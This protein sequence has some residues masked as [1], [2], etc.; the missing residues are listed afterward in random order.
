MPKIVWNEN[1]FSKVKKRIPAIGRIMELSGG[2][3]LG[4][5][6]RSLVPASFQTI[7]PRADFIEVGKDYVHGLLGADMAS[8][9][10]LQLEN[11]PVLL[12]ANHLGVDYHPFV[13]QGNVLFGLA[14]SLSE[15]ALPE[16]KRVMPVMAFGSVSL[17]N[18]VY[19][20]GII[21]SREAASGTLSEPE[22][23]PVKFNVF[24]AGLRRTAASFAPPFS[25]A[26]I[27][28][29]MKAVRRQYMA[30]AIGDRENHVLTDLLENEYLSPDLLERDSYSDQ[31]A[32]INHR[33]WPRL[34]T[35]ETRRRMPDLVSM[36]IERIVSPLIIKDLRDPDS[37]LHRVLFD[38]GL[39]E[40][41]M[42]NLEG[43]FGCWDRKRLEY[44][45]DDDL[46][47][48]ERER[49]L[50][51]SGT[52]FFW[53]IS[54][55]GRLVRLALVFDGGDVYLD[56]RDEY[57]QTYRYPYT[58]DGL[59]RGL[60]DRS[61]LP[62]LFVTF[63]EVAFARG[64]RCFGGFFQAGYLPAMQKGLTGALKKNGYRDWA[65]KVDI[66]STADY[67]TGMTV[68]LAHYRD[69]IQPAGMVEVLS[70]EGIAE[71]DL[72]LIGQLTVDEANL[73][74]LV[75]ICRNFAVEG[76]G[77]AR[78]MVLVDQDQMKRVIRQMVKIKL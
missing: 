77:Q 48:M 17:G 21:L 66:V 54:S 35:R 58:P 9:L 7:Q 49:A 43:I 75:E 67:I 29:A 24:P 13:F 63:L 18:Q 8:R 1:E 16:S 51:K 55:K 78:R 57:G 11:S 61:L 68:I 64:F 22:I 14:T 40:G 5:Y 70:G 39:R 37:L 31:A 15:T 74:G 44:S 41:V 76:N 45:L 12:T 32:L 25:S 3:T 71:R 46:A 38:P 72:D 34:F 27:E 23:R 47:G 30:G 53:A 19:T 52:S 33:L 20:R 4:E 36:E 69:Q 60:L 2:K 26:M 62:G 50:S 42:N 73:F 28:T 65:D 10:A 6:F 59:A 56:G